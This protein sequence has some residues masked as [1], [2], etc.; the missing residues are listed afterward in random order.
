MLIDSHCHLDRL[1]LS[2]YNN[3]LELAILEAQ[4]FDIGYILCPSVVLDEHQ[5]LLQ[6]KAINPEKIAIAVG[7]HPSENV[8]YVITEQELYDLANTP[9]VMA[10]GETGLDYYYVTDENSRAIQR[11][12][13]ITHIQVA[14][15]L[16]KPLIIH[17]RNASHDIIEI[18]QAERADEIC[19]I[20]HC[21]SENWQTA[22]KVLDLGF[23]LGFSGIL[24]FKNAE[25]LREIARKTPENRILLETDSPYLAPVPFRGKSNEP[26]Y[27]IHT[28][29]MMAQIRKVDYKNIATI[30]TNNFWN[31]FA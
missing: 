27:L 16:R 28:A 2:K 24:T 8:D 9:E 11:Q 22:T 1:D 31:I 18:L 20:M 14:K 23:H 17:C 3:N 29:E 30:T 19:G 10:I 4:K 6:I 12:R 26:A 5:K 25:E 21:F 15:K 7:L 13:F